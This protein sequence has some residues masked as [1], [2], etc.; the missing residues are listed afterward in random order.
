M[1]TTVN[2]GILLRN[3]RYCASLSSYE[4]ISDYGILEAQ[5]L[6]LAGGSQGSIRVDL[7]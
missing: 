5:Y 4:A 7:L 3:E 2:T 6:H 1:A